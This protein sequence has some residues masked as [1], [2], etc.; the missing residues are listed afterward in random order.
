[1]TMPE[2]PTIGAIVRCT[3]H[4]TIASSFIMATTLVIF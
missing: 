4:H 3:S 1:V 2:L